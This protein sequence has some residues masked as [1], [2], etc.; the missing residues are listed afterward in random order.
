[1]SDT[2]T[3]V[4]HF[5]ILLDKEDIDGALA[6]LDPAIEWTEVSCNTGQSRCR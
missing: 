1:M 6:I 2:L 4:R 5:Y 3:T